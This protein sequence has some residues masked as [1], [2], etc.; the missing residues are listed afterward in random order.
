MA[1]DVTARDLQKYDGQWVRGKL[2][3]T[4]CP[5]GPWI[6]TADELPEPHGLPVRCLVSREVMQES[7][8]DQLIFRIPYLIEYIS[9]A[10]T[11]LPG[12]L[13]LTGTPSGVGAYRNPP[14]F[15]R[16]GDVVTVEVEG[17]GALSNPCMTETLA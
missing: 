13:I 11:L 14:R 8:T 6:V 17:I 2:L 9:R 5:L 4:F 10:F 15:L 1:N 7:R 3:D 16:D 12:D